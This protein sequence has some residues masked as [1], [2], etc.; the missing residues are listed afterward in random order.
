MVVRTNAK[1]IKKKLRRV[2][3]LKFK[4]TEKYDVKE[5][6]NNKSNMA[7]KITFELKIGKP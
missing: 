3:N 5:I 1:F 6:K 4:L 7:P 2:C